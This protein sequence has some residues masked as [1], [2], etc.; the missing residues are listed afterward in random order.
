M[1]D[2]RILTT[3]IKAEDLQDINVGD[4]VILPKNN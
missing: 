3:P 4:M 2:K 1:T